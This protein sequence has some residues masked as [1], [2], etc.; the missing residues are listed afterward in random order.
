MDRA[1]RR[2][3]LS[4]LRANAGNVTHA[5]RYLGVSHRT[6]CRWIAADPELRVAVD[7]VREERP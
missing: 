4:A 2:A 1:R 3:V 5:A 6:L 7:A